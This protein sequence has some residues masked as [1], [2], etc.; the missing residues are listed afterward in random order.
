[1]VAMPLQPITVEEPFQQWGLYFIRM[2]NLGSS[3]SNRFIL[4]TTN[5]FT[6]CMEDF[7]I[8]YQDH[9]TIISFMERIITRFG[10]S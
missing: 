8:K 4:T 7:V 2:I 3:S 10:I 5:Y 1:M 6:R 9:D